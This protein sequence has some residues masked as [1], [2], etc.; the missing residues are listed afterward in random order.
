LILLPLMAL[1][2]IISLG[3]LTVRDKH[4]LLP[5]HMGAL[6]AFF[7]FGAM[8]CLYLVLTMGGDS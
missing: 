4:G 5:V 1:L 3:C 8:A 7:G 2:A 6:S